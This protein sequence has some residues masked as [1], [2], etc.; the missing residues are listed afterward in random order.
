MERA[1]GSWPLGD[2]PE[3]Q[4]VWGT[5]ENDAEDD[6]DCSAADV[7]ASFE[8]WMEERSKTDVGLR[9]SSELGAV[10]RT[11]KQSLRWNLAKLVGEYARHNGHAD[12]IRERIDGK[13]GE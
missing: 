1:C 4:W 6:I 7:D 2:D 9:E 12:I 11:N 13:T 8:T 3:F 10:S 5:Y